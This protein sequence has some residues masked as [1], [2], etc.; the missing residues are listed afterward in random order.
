MTWRSLLML[1]P[2]RARSDYNSVTVMKQQLNA[3][4]GVGLDEQANFTVTPNEAVQY[5]RASSFALLLEVSERP[6]CTAVCEPGKPTIRW[7]THAHRATTTLNRSTSPR[8][9]MPRPSTHRLRLCR[10]RLIPTTS[11]ASIRH[12]ASICPFLTTTMPQVGEQWASFHLTLY[13]S[14]LGPLWSSSSS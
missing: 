6:S 13:C 9:T 2:L 11:T 8:R 4:C 10:R 3:S 14:Q 7:L 5:Y 12:L 1:I